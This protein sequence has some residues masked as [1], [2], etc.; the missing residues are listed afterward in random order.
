MNGMMVR[1]VRHLG[2][3]TGSHASSFL[4][5]A[6]VLWP[7]CARKRENQHSVGVHYEVIGEASSRITESC[8][9]SSKEGPTNCSVQPTVSQ[10]ATLFGDRAF[11]QG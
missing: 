1:V 10:N 3:K 2:H 9:Y 11:K 4:G 6:G 5:R 8:I 7:M